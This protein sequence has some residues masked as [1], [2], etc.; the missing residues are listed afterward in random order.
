MAEDPLKRAQG[1]ISGT[2]ADVFGPL[3]TP[4]MRLTFIARSTENPDCYLVMSDDDLSKLPGVIARHR[5]TDCKRSQQDA[6]DLLGQRIVDAIVSGGLIRTSCPDA[7]ESGCVTVW[8][9]NAAEQI[10]YMALHESESAG[11]LDGIMH[12]ARR[13]GWDFDKNGTLLDWM[14]TRFMLAEAAERTM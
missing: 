10:G 9:A 1:I 7:P 12:L 3:F 6:A 8:A 13:H 11:T 5:H 4:D 2:M 14:K